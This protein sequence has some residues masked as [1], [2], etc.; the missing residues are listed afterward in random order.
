MVWYSHLFKNFPQFVVIYTVKGFR[1]V[2]EAEVDV[3]EFSCFF[4]DPMDV[5]NLISG[6]SASSKS[7]LNIWKFSVYKLLKSSLESF[8]YFFVSVLN[9][10]NCAVVCT[11]FGIAFL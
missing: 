4:Y 3:L 10:C 11:F 2:N 1:V 5:G 8:E 9:E 7:R 6:S